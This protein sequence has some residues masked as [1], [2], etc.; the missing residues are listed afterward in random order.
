MAQVFQVQRLVTRGRRNSEELAYGLT[1]L[2]AADVSP[3]QLLQAVR[4]HWHIE[5]RLH[6]R[7][8][9][10]LGEDACLLAQHPAARI[11]ALLNNVVLFLIDHSGGAG[12]AAAKIREFAAT[13]QLALDLILLPP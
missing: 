7:R 12:N 3:A 13:P 10:T 6:Y 5:N 9:V 2:S 4:R 11:L 1:S 8:D